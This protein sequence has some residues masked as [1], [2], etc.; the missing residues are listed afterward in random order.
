MNFPVHATR[1][2]ALAVALGLSALLA[3]CGGGDPGADIGEQGGWFLH[4]ALL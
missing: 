3:S 4:G 1:R 2:A